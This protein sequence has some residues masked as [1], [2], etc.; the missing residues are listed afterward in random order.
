METKT[1][2]V[3]VSKDPEGGWLVEGNG[4]TLSTHRDKSLAVKAGRLL[5]KRHAAEFT[6]H[7]KD[8]TVL[9]TKSYGRSPI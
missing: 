7:R 1:N 8:G 3:H 6:V 2:D 5:A 9:E 4:S